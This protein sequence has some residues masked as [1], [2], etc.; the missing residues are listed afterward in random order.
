MS[1]LDLS[2][3]LLLD[4]SSSSFSSSSSSPFRMF[5][6]LYLSKNMNLNMFG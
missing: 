3:L 5:V 2:F 1:Y 4:L 6:G